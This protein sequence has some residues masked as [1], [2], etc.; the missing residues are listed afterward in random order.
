MSLCCINTPKYLILPLVKPCQSGYT[1][2]QYLIVIIVFKV[3]EEHTN[4]DYSRPP[5]GYL[6]SGERL[7]PTTAIL[8]SSVSAGSQIEHPPSHRSA[9]QTISQPQSEFNASSDQNYQQPLISVSKI[10]AL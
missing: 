9:N 5:P 4:P 3:R 1:I 2:S 6:P 8:S 7:G 10:C